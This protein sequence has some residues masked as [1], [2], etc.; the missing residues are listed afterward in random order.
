L[1]VG[2]RLAENAHSDP[3]ANVRL[4]NLLL[5]VWQ[6][7]DGPETVAALRAACSD[8]SPK[9]RL[10][11]AQELGTEG[12]DVLIALA[13]GTEDDTWSAQAVAIVGRDLPFERTSAILTRAL[14]RRRLQTARA[15]L[16]ALGSGGAAEAVEILAKVL[17]R[18]K[19][20]LAATAAQ[21]LGTTGSPAAEAPLILA[22]QREHA[23]VRVAAANALARLGTA[24]AVLPLKDAV[25]RWADDPELSRAARQAIAAIQTRLPGATPG[26]LSLAGTEAGQ[27]SL[28]PSEPGQLSLATDPAGQLSLTGGGD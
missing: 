24:A 3:D 5:L 26:Q 18:E 28:A 6:L 9:V 7:R 21:A 19:G 27:L 8:P 10:R 14:R 13:E 20:D 16:E 1:D 2:Q 15:C 25:E 4:R 12:R 22:L 11:A 17:G 23:K